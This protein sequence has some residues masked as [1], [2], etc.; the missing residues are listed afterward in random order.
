MKEENK[1]FNDKG[2]NMKN[3]RLKMKNKNKKDKKNFE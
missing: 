1:Q 3:E 2:N